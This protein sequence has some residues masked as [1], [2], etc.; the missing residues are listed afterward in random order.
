MARRGQPSGTP[1]Y[2]PVNAGVAP[3]RALND[4]NESAFSR[5]LRTEIYAPEKLVGNIN[6]ATALGMFAAG[7]IVVRTWGDLMIVA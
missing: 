5:F 1:S 6:V 3:K 4:P 2:I 7:I